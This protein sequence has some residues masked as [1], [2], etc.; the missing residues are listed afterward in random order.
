MWSFVA[1]KKSEVYI[2]LAI[3]RNSAK[4][5]VFLWA[6]ERENQPVSCGLLCQKFISNVLL[7]MGFWQAYKTVIPHK[8]H[9]AVDKK[10]V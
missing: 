4:L 3:D 8:R 6:I 10:Q 7:L 2:W 9:R 5:S 1:R